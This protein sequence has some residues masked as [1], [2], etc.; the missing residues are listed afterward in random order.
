MNGKRETGGGVTQHLVGH[1]VGQQHDVAAVDAHAVVHH[2]V[3]DLVDDGGAS[4]LDAQ[5]LLHLDRRGNGREEIQYSVTT[6]SFES[7]VPE[8]ESVRLVTLSG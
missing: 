5:R 1:Q 8:G 2:G 7:L 3:L 4:S 6:E